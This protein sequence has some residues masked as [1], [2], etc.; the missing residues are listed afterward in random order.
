M[1]RIKS[2]D[3]KGCPNTSLNRMIKNVLYTGIIKNGDSQSQYIEELQIIDDNMFAQAQEIM[4]Q[5]TQPHSSIPL[6]CKGK[7]LLVGN[8]YCAHC[9]NRLTLTTSGR[10]KKM[11]DGTIQKEVRMRYQCHYNVRHPGECEGQSGYSVQKVDGIVDQ[12]IRMKF[13]EIAAASESEILSS[14]HEK[15]IELARSKYEMAKKH[16]LDKQKELDGL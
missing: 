3:G 9:G 11:P 14:Q 15:D 8:I 13:S 7:S 4:R 12:L 5:R 10:N 2:R 1:L 6:N 16:L